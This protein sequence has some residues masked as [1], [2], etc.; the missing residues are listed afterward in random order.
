MRGDPR[1]YFWDICNSAEAI[2]SFCVNRTFDDYQEDM[3]FRSAVERQ[4]EIIGEA[5][6]RLSKTF[7]E[8]TDQIPNYKEIIS[9]RNMLIHG[10]A[11][12]DNAIVW[13]AVQNDLPSLYAAVKLILT[14]LGAEPSAP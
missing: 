1:A 10:Y 6:N 14:R 4:F 9:F 13:S 7:P 12:I 11:T 3:M 2:F 5:I 8:Y